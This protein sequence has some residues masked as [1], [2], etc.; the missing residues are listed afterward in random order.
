M[1]C[2]VVQCFLVSGVGGGGWGGGGRGRGLES[3]LAQLPG[4]LSSVGT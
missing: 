2:E 4:T 3:W 1:N